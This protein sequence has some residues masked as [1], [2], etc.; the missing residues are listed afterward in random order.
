MNRIIHL[1]LRATGPALALALSTASLADSVTLRASARVAPGA[2]VR[3]GDIADLEGAE[4]ERLASVEV[5]RA[6]AGAFEIALDTVRQRAVDAGADPSRISFRGERTVVR[7]SRGGAKKPAAE[8]KPVAVAAAAEPITTV[9]DP[10]T[11]GGVATPVAIACELVRNAHARHG[12]ALRIEI[13]RDELARIEP[14]PG[15]RY[16]VAPKSALA[17]D[18][19]DLEVT[20]FRGDEIVRRERVRMHVRVEREVAVTRS[21]A[22]RGETIAAETIAVE[23]RLVAASDTDAIADP[24]AVREATLA[25]SV[26]EGAM[27]RAE[28]LARQVAVRRNER[29]IVRREIGMVAIELEAVALEDGAPGE[30]I[31]LER[32]GAARARDTR[33]ISA[34]VIG[35]GRAVIR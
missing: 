5:A 14:E 17:A 28:D 22:K 9:I 33:T 7:P 4:A 1:F 30:T 26:A 29:V 15:I 19:I 16:E 23:R 25:R 24:K 18:R 12:D 8:A 32:R 3:I 10:A 27:L 2:P 6:D 34:E 13:S 21:A 20:A 31:A 35:R 11:L